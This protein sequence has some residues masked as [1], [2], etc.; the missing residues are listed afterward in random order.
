MSVSGSRPADIGADAVGRKAP[1][2]AGQ[3]SMDERLAELIRLIESTGGLAPTHGETASTR[4]PE[5]RQSTID[6]APGGPREM[7]PVEPDAPEAF[8]S[9]VLPLRGGQEASDATP[10]GPLDAQGF[11]ARCRR[12]GAARRGFRRHGWQVRSAEGAS[13]RSR[14]PGSGEGAAAEPRAP[15]RLRATPGRSRPRTC[16]RLS[17]PPPRSSRGRRTSRLASPPGDAPQPPAMA[18]A[19]ATNDASA[20]RRRAPIGA[21]AVADPTLPAGGAADAGFR[22]GAAG[23]RLQR[24][25]PRARRRPPPSLTRTG[26]RTLARRLSSLPDRR[27]TPSARRL[28]LRRGRRR[29]PN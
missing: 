23:Y 21:P 14:R 28:R 27:R 3:E 15:P 13:G 4:G 26:S 18:P 17:R 10:L 29:N 24:A 19:Q 8:E 7:I 6:S 12:R 16:S 11:G 20:G 1:A 25:P 2:H 5:P 22:P 9:G